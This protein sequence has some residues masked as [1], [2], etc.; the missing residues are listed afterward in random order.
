MS[1]AEKVNKSVSDTIKS[2][3][4]FIDSTTKSLQAEFSKR[5]P[6]IEHALDRSL[7]QAGQSLSDALTSLDN[8][9]NR[10]QLELLEGY[11]TFLQGQVAFVDERIEAI[12]KGSDSKGTTKTQ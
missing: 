1:T 8:K 2:M 6:E 4:E 5:A 11:R 3:E 10:E 12:K 7:E 9:T